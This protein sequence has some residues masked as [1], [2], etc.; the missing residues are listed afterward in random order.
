MERLAK[1][2]DGEQMG[3]AASGGG[4]VAELDAAAATVEEDAP[5]AKEE[6]AEA[7]VEVAEVAEA[8]EAAEAVHAADVAEAA[9]A[10]HAADVA[11]AAAGAAKVGHRSPVQGVVA[12][13]VE[14][15]AAEETVG[16]ADADMLKREEPPAA[17]ANDAEASAP[18]PEDDDDDETV[19]SAQARL[20]AKPA[21]EDAPG[22]SAEDAPA[23]SADDA[24]AAADGDESGR[25]SGRQR[26]PSSVAKEAAAAEEDE[27]V[28]KPKAARGKA[29]A[30]APAAKAPA[31]K[32]VRGKKAEGA[33]SSGSS[34]TATAG[35]AAAPAEALAPAVAAAAAASGG[36]ST[37]SNSAWAALLIKKKQEVV[38][39][40]AEE[41]EK[42]KDKPPP[43]ADPKAEARAR[44]PVGHLRVRGALVPAGYEADLNAWR[45][46][47]SAPI[48]G[49]TL[50]HSGPERM[51][52]LWVRTDH[53]WYWLK[54]VPG[55]SFF[56]AHIG[57]FLW[58]PPG[59]AGGAPIGEALFTA[60]PISCSYSSTSLAPP[61]RGLGVGLLDTMASAPFTTAD[62]ADADGS[63]RAI[64]FS[65]FVVTDADGESV[66]LF[67]ALPHGVSAPSSSP[68]HL[69][70]QALPM[71]Q[72]AGGGDKER[73]D[74]KAKGDGGDRGDAWPARMWVRSLPVHEWRVQV[75][76]SAAATAAASRSADGGGGGGGAS[77]AAKPKIW[78]R[79]ASSWF[80]LLKPRVDLTWRPPGCRDR[81]MADALLPAGLSSPDRPPFENKSDLPCRKLVCFT[82]HA[83][84]GT[85]TPILR[86]LHQLA[87]H[88]DAPDAKH[89]YARGCVGG[90]SKLSVVNLDDERKGAGVSSTNVAGGVWVSTGDILAGKVDYTTQP[91]SVWVRTAAALYMLASP[92]DE[93]APLYKLPGASRAH[94]LE[95]SALSGSLL[96]VFQRHEEHPFT[97][98]KGLV[99]PALHLSEFELVD[100]AG[101]PRSVLKTLPEGTL[102]AAEKA[103]KARLKAAG[104]EVPAKN[105]ADESGASPYE[106]LNVYV[107]ARL[108]PVGCSASARPWVRAGPV[109]AWS[110]DFDKKGGDGKG[111]A[112]LWLCSK[113]AALYM[114][115][116]HVSTASDAHS[117]AWFTGD[118]LLV[119]YTAELLAGCR[120]HRDPR[121]AVKLYN[122]LTATAWARM[123]SEVGAKYGLRK[124][125]LYEKHVTPF[126]VEALQD[127]G[128]K[129]F[130]ARV[131]EERKRAPAPRAPNAPKPT[132]AAQPPKPPPPKPIAAVE[133]KD[134]PKGNG[135]G[136]GS[137][138]PATAPPGSGDGGNGGGAAAKAPKLAAGAKAGAGEKP[139]AP[140]AKAP[141][142]A[143]A[144]APTKEIDDADVARTMLAVLR[145]ASAPLSFAQIALS[146]KDANP[147]AMWNFARWLQAVQRGIK[148]RPSWFANIGAEMLG[149]GAGAGIEPAATAAATAPPPAAGPPAAALG[150]VA[151]GG[152]GAARPATGG[153]GLGGVATGGPGA[154]AA[155]G[156]GLARAAPAAMS[157]LDEEL[158]GADDD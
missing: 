134:D 64:R 8:A 67:S 53:C 41:A 157:K 107:R 12:M 137:K 38:D 75:D 44:V 16:G 43:K 140:P 135:A 4:G 144:P 79:S 1:E 103:E 93:Y 155:G 66:D 122:N 96:S 131:E 9:E 118:G 138:R 51:R 26:K 89:T 76:T 2:E 37:S 35:A 28:G 101:A 126:V 81:P 69:L 92:A 59:S 141:K 110:I 109:R 127:A 152:P 82:V 19:T 146:C 77:G 102:R 121:N 154:V 48:R 83:A 15:E 88:P 86:L 22:A 124:E 17:S 11:E 13:E 145:K 10:V 148:A 72:S 7:K 130:A 55:T 125:V 149:V 115:A 62:A 63:A 136:G 139:R 49:W 104:K 90:V 50:Q 3:T 98:K 91:P 95:E 120:E 85:L 61:P 153:P 113:G 123:P 36:F 25:R 42:E 100:A 45:Y 23:A 54:S 6:A 132:A 31:A 99:I 68:V 14:E 156:P 46:V 106:A 84:D 108:L 56:V 58:A 27:E 65:A 29:T 87:N 133:P 150:G 116:K 112:G 147:A 151:T 128:H 52:S 57:R 24:P 33:A 97:S 111:V 21:A 94:P 20:H 129:P 32:A 74:D 18:A 119:H 34:S 105:D 158:F 39:K 114:A 142:P 143:P 5:A 73:G 60:S 47:L 117:K 40:A 78:V 80:L 70:G 71:Q 30:K